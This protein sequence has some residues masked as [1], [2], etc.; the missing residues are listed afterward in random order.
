MNTLSNKLDDAKCHG[1]IN[2]IRRTE[3]RGKGEIAVGSF[4]DRGVNEEK[5]KI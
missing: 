5:N 3:N 4:T 1:E 2:L